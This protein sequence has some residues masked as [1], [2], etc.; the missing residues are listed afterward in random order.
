MSKM[1]E[2]M[3]FLEIIEFYLKF[4]LI[5]LLLRW[6]LSFMP[7]KIF[8]LISFV[9]NLIRYPV[10][11][12]FY[13][14]YGVKVIETDLEKSLF[15]T[16]EEVNDFD[17]RMTSNVIGPLLILTYAGSFLF[18][19]ANYLYN[20][21]QIWISI[22][23]Y[24]LAFA[25]ILMSA[26]SYHESEELIKVS[27]KSIFKWLGKIAV[28]SLPIY[29]LIYYLAGAE[30]LAQGAFVLT[31]MIPFYHHKRDLK[32]EKMV[33]SKKAKVLEVDPFGE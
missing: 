25:I 31:L 17:C 16:E 20:I 29:F 5:S 19:W 1:I 11:R 28:L 13:W 2:D 7:G 9:G 10:K 15:L 3:F 6:L 33:K 32:E 4:W 23:L 24:V 12:F 18:Y 27:I 30:T 22:V 14:L 26:P 21:N 8:E